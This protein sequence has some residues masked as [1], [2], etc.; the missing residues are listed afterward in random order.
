MQRQITLRWTT[1]LILAGCMHAQLPSQTP[2][3][4][5]FVGAQSAPKRQGFFDYVLGKINPRNKDYGVTLESARNAI[6]ENS[7]HDLYF[8]S[9]V[10][11][12]FLLTAAACVIFLQWRSMDKRELIAA[13]LIAQLWNGRASDRIEIER[14]TEQFNQLV[15]VHNAEVERALSAKSKPSDDGEHADSELKRTV[16]RLENRQ[17]KAGVVARGGARTPALTAAADNQN[18]GDAATGFEQRNAMLELQVEA[19]KNTEANLRKRLNDTLV[20]LEQERTRNQRLK[21]A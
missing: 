3:R 14:R 4:P 11:S 1:I 16:D 5:A 6:V 13:S 9:N 17:A 15:E 20:Q 19:M 10:V 12:L 2:S 18:A 8:W 7:V 21:G